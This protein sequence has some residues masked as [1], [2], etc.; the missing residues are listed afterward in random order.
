MK[1]ALQPI[2]EPTPSRTPYVV[3]IGILFV[4]VILLALFL[5]L[6]VSSAGFTFF[7][8]VNA[9][10]IV[11]PPPSSLDPP[12]SSIPPPPYQPLWNS[13]GTSSRVCTINS[14][15]WREGGVPDTFD[16]F[17][18]FTSTVPVGVY[19]LTLPQYMQFAYCNGRISCVSGSYD[20]ID[21]TTS[22]QSS[23]FK[24]AEG[25]AD[26]VAIYHSTS[27]GE[28]TPDIRIASNPYPAPTGICKTTG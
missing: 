14:T 15:G 16:Y 18:T 24:L 25:C 23:V 7:R 1:V 3:V 6:A 9:P 20:R 10:R 11:P 21:A 22:I 26:Y 4:V 19:F 12:P 2:M 27:N 13:C 17:V 28:M 5:G 8:G